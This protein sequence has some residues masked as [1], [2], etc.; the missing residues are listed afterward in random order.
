MLFYF[1]VKYATTH[2]KMQAQC[3]QSIF[4]KKMT[5]GE[6]LGGLSDMEMH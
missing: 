3:A 6:A 2:K 1:A 5:L 4:S